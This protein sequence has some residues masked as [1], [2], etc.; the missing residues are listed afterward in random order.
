VFLV[1][2]GVSESRGSVV[3]AESDHID[4]IVSCIWN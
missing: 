3:D 1:M 2:R 4:Y